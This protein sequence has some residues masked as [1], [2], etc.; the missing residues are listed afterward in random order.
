MTASSTFI[1]HKMTV[2]HEEPVAYTLMAGDDPIEMN[3]LVGERIELRFTG[4][5]E[6]VSCGQPTR[7][8]FNQGHCYRCFTTLA[9]C[10]RCIMSPELCHYSRGTCRDPAWGEANCMRPH[11]V[12]LANSSGLKVG[13]TRD[14][15]VPTRWID[16]GARAAMPVFEV[17]TRRDSGLLED[18]LRAF[19]SDRTDWRAMLRGDP[20]TLDLPESRDQLLQKA[21][22]RISEVPDAKY[23][24]HAAPVAI[25]YPVDT[26]PEK[27]RSLTADKTPVVTGVLQGIKGQYLIL[28]A[29]VFNVRRHGG[30]EVQLL[31]GVGPR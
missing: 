6:C 3:A 22:T 15:Q 1:L 26:Y 14:S 23:L 11:I 27:V 12:Y 31:Y 20:P 28:D 16:Q 18:G 5:I 2:R 24:A 7:K 29:G 4:R 21:A 17:P 10:D 25:S 8:S 30:Y 19:V 9:S 13:I